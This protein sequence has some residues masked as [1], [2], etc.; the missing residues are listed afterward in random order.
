MSPLDFSGEQYEGSGEFQVLP[1]NSVVPLILNIERDKENQDPASNLFFA[2]SKQNDVFFMKWK[3]TV[4]AGQYKD[5]HFWNNMTVVG[6]TRNKNG[7]SMGG[8]IT[9][10]MT[11]QIIESAS[12]INKEDSSPEAAAARILQNDWLDLDKIIF[13]GNVGVEA[14]SG[15]YPEK[16]KLLSG[17]MP[18]HKKWYEW[19]QGSGGAVAPAPTTPAAQGTGLAPAGTPVAAPGAPGAPGAPPAGGMGFTPP[20]AAQPGGGAAPEG[21][22]RPEWADS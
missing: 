19:R 3:L 13:L 10:R 9:G 14:A 16:N 11:R 4:M 2:S 17:V 20:P 1:A 21:G 18:G 22:E 8:V 6:G 12:G 7:E 15:S 5:T